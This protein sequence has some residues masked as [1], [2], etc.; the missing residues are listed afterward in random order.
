MIE[1]PKSLTIRRHWARPTQ[2]QIDA[3][4]G[5]PTSFVVDAMD[6][7]GALDMSIRPIGDGRDLNCVAVGP[8]LTADNGPADVLATLAALG[9]VQPGDVLVAGNNAHQGTAVA[10]DRV[11]GMLRNSG[12]AGFVTDGPMR[13]YQGIVDAGL[14]A[15]CTGLNPASPFSSGPGRIGLPLQIGGQTVNSGD[16]IVADRDGVVV[17]PFDQIDAV[18]DRLTHVCALEKKLDGEV[19]NGRRTIDA[20]MARIENGGAVFVD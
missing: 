10:G 13:D 7:R 16:M 15:W 8:A 5:M 4:K 9:Y 19:A 3:F 17:V 2:A 11:M 18:I 12:G 6:G 1:E 14:P 20:I